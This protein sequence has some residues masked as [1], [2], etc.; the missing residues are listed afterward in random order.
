MVNELAADVNAVI[1]DDQFRPGIKRTTLF[2]QV[3]LSHN[4]GAVKAMLECGALV[5][6]PDYNGKNELAK[7]IIG[8]HCSHCGSYK[9]N[10]LEIARILLVAGSSMDM[11]NRRGET[12]L[13][14]PN[15]I[16]DG[17]SFK[18]FL[19]A[20]KEKVSRLGGCVRNYNRACGQL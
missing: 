1:I 15:N 18:R 4:V 14:L 13:S 11:K 9:E 12:A 17:G 5:N 20:H 2:H 3:C 6:R 7:L 19:L 10:G 16:H 8:D